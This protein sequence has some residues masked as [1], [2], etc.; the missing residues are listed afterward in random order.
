MDY[1]NIKSDK[2]QGFTLSIKSTF[3]EKPQGV[4][5][6]SLLPSRFR[7]N[8]EVDEVGCRDGSVVKYH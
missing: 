2:N 3:L 7:V 5:S 4:W 1:D 6:N 8:F